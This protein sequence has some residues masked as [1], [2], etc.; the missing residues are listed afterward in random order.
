[1][2]SCRYAW[3]AGARISAAR[4]RRTRAGVST[5][6]TTRYPLGAIDIARAFARGDFSARELVD[7]ALRRIES[8]D[9]FVNAFTGLVPQQALDHATR[10]DAFRAPGAPFPPLPAS[11]FPPK[12][13]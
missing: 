2:R 7:D 10:L 4:A 12:P 13:L 6:T 5:M 1:M 9:R 3:G 8:G 11:P